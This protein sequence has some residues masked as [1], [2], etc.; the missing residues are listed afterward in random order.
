[1]LFRDD[2]GSTQRS[3]CCLGRISS[4][5]PKQEKPG[6]SC[7]HSEQSMQRQWVY[8]GQV[9]CWEKCKK[10][11]IQPEGARTGFVHSVNMRNRIIISLF[12][13]QWAMWQQVK[14]FLVFKVI[15]IKKMWTL[16]AR[17]TP[18]QDSSKKPKL[19]RSLLIWHMVGTDVFSLFAF[20]RH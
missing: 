2:F 17:H 5:W 7:G 3:C 1:M 9:L 11:N 6:P 14:I 19:L 20:F 4:V 8:H 18:Y 13:L 12:W 16:W 15:R 10:E